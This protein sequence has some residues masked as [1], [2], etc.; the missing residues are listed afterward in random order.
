M[1]KLEARCILVLLCGFEDLNLPE[2]LADKDNA[3]GGFGV[4]EPVGEDPAGVTREVR[5]QQVF[6]LFKGRRLF[7]L[8][9]LRCRIRRRTRS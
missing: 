3:G 2:E 8:P 1:A 6:E 9:S 7:P 4:D 5:D